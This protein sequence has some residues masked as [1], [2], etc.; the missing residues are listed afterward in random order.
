MAAVVDMAQ[1]DAWDPAFLEQLVPASYAFS[2][3][4]GEKKVQDLRISGGGF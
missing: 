2:L 3:A 1:D 4:P